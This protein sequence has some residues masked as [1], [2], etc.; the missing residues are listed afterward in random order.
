MCGRFVS[1]SP[2]GEIAAYFG[3]EVPEVE[4][5][6]N[7][8]VAP[9]SDVYAVRE[10]ADASR[11]IEAFHWGLVPMWAKDLKVGNRMINAR[12][13]T[14]AEKN[15]FKRALANRRCLLPADGF[16]E[17]KVVGKTDKG[18]PKKQPMYIQRPDGEL[19]AMAGLWERWRG[20]DRDWDNVLH[21]TTVVTTQANEFMAPI[22]NRMPVFLSPD[23]W[24]VWLDP[25]VTDFD[26]L[27][28][29][30]KPAP[31]ALLTAHPVDPMVGNV[32]NKGAQLIVPFEPPEQSL[33][34][35]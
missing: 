20:P 23:A 31:E 2:P 4:L 14:L 10:G 3:A 12:S 29:L 21:S 28:S 5:P 34:L 27:T 11:S 32:R 9:T 15:T 19:L 13:E 7:H 25:E 35:G 18:K 17:W 24:E 6:A 8:N 22:H 33:D 26:L 30:L 16:Y 1:A